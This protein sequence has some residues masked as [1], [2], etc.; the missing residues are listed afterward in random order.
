MEVSGKTNINHFKDQLEYQLFTAGIYS[1]LWKLRVVNKA[2]AS[3]Q[4]KEYHWKWRAAG[5]ELRKR[6]GNES[7]FIHLLLDC[8]RTMILTVEE[9]KS[10]Y[11]DTDL[12]LFIFQISTVKEAFIDISLPIIEERVSCCKLHSLWII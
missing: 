11:H 5:V 6:R 3:M 12:Q 9:I 1:K 8:S 7:I 4:T 10:F 2:H